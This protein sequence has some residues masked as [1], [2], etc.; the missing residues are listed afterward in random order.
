MY[1]FAKKII[2]GEISF[3]EDILR[4][5]FE[6]GKKNGRKGQ[7]MYLADILQLERKCVR[8]DESKAD[9]G[10]CIIKKEQM[11][12]LVGW[13]PDFWESL[14]MRQDFEVSQRT[15]AIPSWI[16]NF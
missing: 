14:M 7:V 9:K 8:Q 6:V 2:A 13:S 1:L 3:N 10:W 16:R 11:K 15:I 5:K 12:Q 4:R